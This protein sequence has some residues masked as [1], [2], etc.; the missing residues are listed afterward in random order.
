MAEIDCLNWIT[1][2]RLPF[3]NKV[4]DVSIRLPPT[5]HFQTRCGGFE[6]YICQVSR[7]FSDCDIGRQYSGNDICEAG[8][9][10]SGNTEAIHA[11]L[12]GAELVRLGRLDF[13]QMKASKV[14]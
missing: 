13:I 2:K 1:R 9:S 4:S 12:K 8:M 10:F 11:I 14:F 3:Q 5:I 6:I 7:G